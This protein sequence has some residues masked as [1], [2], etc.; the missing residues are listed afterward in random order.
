MTLYRD[1]DGRSTQVERYGASAAAATNR[2]KEALRDRVGDANG[3]DEVTA[4]SRVT[5]LAEHWWADFSTQDKS[6]GTFR[7]YRD[8]LDKQIIPGLGS[9]RIRELT[10]AVINR[11]VKT[12]GEKHGAGIAKLVRTILSN[13]CAHACRLDAMT[14]N[15]C[16]EVAAVKPKV[17]KVPRALTPEELSQVRA[18]FTY[19]PAAMRQ[20]LPDITNMMLATTLRIA[21]VLAIEWPNV[22]LDK[23]TVTTGAVVV[24]VK[25]Q[26][27]VI[28]YDATSKINERTLVLPKWGVDLLKRRW[29]TRKPSKCKY[30]PVFLSSVGTLRDP[31][32]VDGQFR[33]AHD[34]MGYEWIVPHHYR[35]TGATWLDQAGLSAR[36]IADQLGHSKTSM[37]LDKYM[38]RGATNPRVAAALDSLAPIG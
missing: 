6:P 7:L 9:I 26:G 3:R 16:R 15:P 18:S 22:D 30:D 19:D 17:K 11:H 34:R 31:N 21:E 36:E 25:G 23:G 38:G 29:E 33:E 8:R 24:R 35:K 12:V 2:L 20:E 14:I 10:T 5:D 28:K 27:L 37:T 13:M 4:D 1:Y 32:N